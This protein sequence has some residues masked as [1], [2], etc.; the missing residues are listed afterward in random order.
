[1]RTGEACDLAT[2][3]GKLQSLFELR[4][5]RRTH[6]SAFASTAKVRFFARL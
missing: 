1:M 5:A 4:L 6:C 3:Q 2:S